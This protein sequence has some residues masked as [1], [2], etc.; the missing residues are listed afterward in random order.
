MA[1]RLTR[2]LV[3]LSMLDV[4]LG[5]SQLLVVNIIQYNTMVRRLTR[6][7]V[8]LSML[9]VSLGVSQ[10]LVVNSIQ[11]NTNNTVNVSDT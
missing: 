8:C 3:C 4:S 5:D 6:A 7:L 9:D 10:L 11:Y 1:W 2:A